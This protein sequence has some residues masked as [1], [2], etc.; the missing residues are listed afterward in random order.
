MNTPVTLE[1]RR[2]F[3]AERLKLLADE[4][5]A[6]GPAEIADGSAC[7][8]ATGSGGRGEMSPRSDLDIFIVEYK[9]KARPL[10]NL[11]EIRWV[12]ILWNG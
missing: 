12:Q 10:T 4:L 1:Q 2:A 7:V 6:A 3:T 5:A 8:Y 9:D 11:N